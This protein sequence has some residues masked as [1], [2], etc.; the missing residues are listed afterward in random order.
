MQQIPTR[1][2]RG[3]E[4]AQRAPSAARRTVARL[5]RPRRLLGLAVLAALLAPC[6]LVAA[7][8]LCNP[9][10]LHQFLLAQLGV[11]YGT[12]TAREAG[13]TLLSAC[14][15]GWNVLARRPSARVPAFGEDR[16]MFD[17]VFSWIPG[18]A[19]VHPTEGFYYWELPTE[20]RTLHGNLR[21]ADLRRGRISMAYFETSE[22]PSRHVR[23]TTDD[24]L[25]VERVSDSAYDV[26]WAGRT[27][28]FV[29]PTL[30]LQPPRTLRML[31]EEEFMG[32]IHDESGIRF[33]LIFNRATASFYD[34]L[35]EEQGV[36]DELVALDERL[37]LGARTGFVYFDDREYDRRL[38]VGVDLARVAANDYLDGPGDQVPYQI[39]MREELHLAYPNTLLGGGVD[40]H[41][42]YVAKEPWTRVAVS[43]FHRYA[44]LAEVL[45]RNAACS[46]DQE[47]SALWTELT[48][49][50]WNTPIY[51]A[52]VLRRL[53]QEAEGHLTAADVSREGPRSS[54]EAHGG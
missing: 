25:G 26:T 19:V 53:A 31:P 15:S 40:P 45:E 1:P 33:F 2:G 51:R 42:V 21:V 50:W 30:G 4:P 39:D 48:K 7:H 5:G 44:R 29:L 11:R 38:L 8:A 43:P 37:L 32:Q 14:A 47:R 36:N 18:R 20:G 23:L 12:L 34:V 35:N 9:L 17:F 3:R 22:G 13:A 10:R 24:G 41:G 46:L 27:V 6:V 49:E 28:R 16:A 54:T 52:W